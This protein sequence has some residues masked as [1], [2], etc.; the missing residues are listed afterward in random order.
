MQRAVGVLGA[1]PVGKQHQDVVFPAG[2]RGAR[3]ER[4]LIGAVGVVAQAPAAQVNIPAGYVQKLHPVLGRAGGGGQAGQVFGAQL[5]DQHGMAVVA[6]GRQRLPHPGKARRHH[7]RHR[8]QRQR[9]AQQALVQRPV[10]PML[11]PL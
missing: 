5:V 3:R 2:Q 9:S 6:A 10:H 8:Q 11:S 1:G 4:P 7:C